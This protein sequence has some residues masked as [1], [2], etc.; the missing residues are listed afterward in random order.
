MFQ[1]SL[2]AGVTIKTTIDRNSGI[3]E[4]DPVRIAQVV[5]ELCTNAIHAMADKE[6]ILQV[7][8]RRHYLQAEDISEQGVKPG[9][10]VVLSVS[11]NGSGMGQDIRQHIF[12]PYYT[13]REVGSGSGLGL[14]VIHG[15]IRDYHGMI[16]VESDLGVGTSVVVYIPAQEEERDTFVD[17][18]SGKPVG[19]ERILVLDD[20]RSIVKVMKIGLENL[21]YQVTV[22]TKSRNALKLLQERPEEFDLLITDQT[23]PELTGMELAGELLKSR[24][25]FPIIL[26]TGYSACVSE[27]DALNLGIRRFVAKPVVGSELGRVVRK[28]L[29]EV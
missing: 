13:T 19:C 24:P 12:E 9:A 1:S 25:D 20:E 6:G 27:Q 16:R 3:I 8:L 5:V 28:V 11:D 15:I 17:G 22:T 23:M 26:C 14:A 21:G 29:D 18:S 10:F 7:N 2:P 4:A